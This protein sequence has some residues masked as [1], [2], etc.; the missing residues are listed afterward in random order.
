MTRLCM[1]NVRLTQCNPQFPEIVTSRK[2]S[3]D[4][5]EVTRLTSFSPGSCEMM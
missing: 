1:V 2:I 3:V 5:L 4:I